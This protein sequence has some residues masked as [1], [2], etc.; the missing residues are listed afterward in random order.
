MFLFS[1]FSNVKCF[2]WY[3]MSNDISRALI[4]PETHLCST[5]HGLPPPLC[6]RLSKLIDPVLVLKADGDWG[7]TAGRYRLLCHLFWWAFVTQ[8]RGTAETGWV[9]WSYKKFLHFITFQFSY[10][11]QKIWLVSFF[12]A[13]M[14]NAVIYLCR[15]CNYYLKYLHFITFPKVYISQIYP[16]KNG[17]PFFPWQKI[18]RNS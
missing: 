18:W 7:M 10:F 17:I 4:S 8:Q 16:E 3:Q 9:S 6:A 12:V 11:L 1:C 14:R 5:F 2:K 13:N 15:S